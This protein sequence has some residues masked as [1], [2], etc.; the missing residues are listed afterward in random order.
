MGTWASITTGAM[1]YFSPA[2]REGKLEKRLGCF[3]RG[4]S[5]D[6]GRMVLEKEGGRGGGRGKAD[7]KEEGRKKESQTA[8]G[9]SKSVVRYRERRKEYTKRRTS[10]EYF[11]VRRSASE[12]QL[13]PSMQS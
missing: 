7:L 9:R 10:P 11:F 1:T 13:P 4:V 12:P 5:L 8:E 2:A 3:G 6:E